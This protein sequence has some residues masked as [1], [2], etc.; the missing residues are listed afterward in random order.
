MASR[1]HTEFFICMRNKASMNR[2]YLAEQVT[3]ER[4]TLVEHEMTDVE[5]NAGSRLLGG[6][7]PPEWLDALDDVQ[8]HLDR[9]PKKITE[10]ETLHDKHL[11]RPT[12]DD[13]AEDERRIET[14]TKEISRIF[15]HAQGLLL[16]IKAK[17][18]GKAEEEILRQNVMRSV[19][20]ALQDYSASFRQVQSSYVRALKSREDWSDPYF[21]V[22]SKM[23]AEDDL[24]ATYSNGLEDALRDPLFGIK[25]PDSVGGI[26]SQRQLL[27]RMEEDTSWADQRDKEISQIVKSIVQ[28]NELFR[29]LSQMVVEQGTVLD[30]IDYNIENSSVSV[31]EGLQQLRKAET[32]QRKNRKI[33]CIMALAGTSVFLL[34]ILVLDGRN[35]VLSNSRGDRTTPTVVAVSSEERLIGA[36]AKQ[37][38]GRPGIDI[39]QG[40]KA[41]V[42]NPDPAQ[43][44]SLWPHSGFV[45]TVESGPVFALTK[46]GDSQEVMSVEEALNIVFNEFMEIARS[47]VTKLDENL[48]AVLTVP[49]EFD[50]QKT[51]I[52]KRAAANA[53]FNVIQA[54][55][56]PA[57]AVL[58]YDIAQKDSLCTPTCLV[59]RVGGTTSDITIVS[60]TSG[61]YSIEGHRYYATLGGDLLTKA[62]ADHFRSEF[63]SKYKMDPCE[64]SRRA[65]HKLFAAAEEC[66]HVLST[67]PSSSAFVESLRDGVDFSSNVTRARFESVANVHWDRFLVPVREILA[68]AGLG[69][70]DIDVVILAG[71]TMKIPKLQKLVK[72]MF[73]E[74]TTLCFSIP[75]DEVVAVGAAQQAGIKANSAL[76]APPA[77]TELVCLSRGIFFQIGEE[78][79]P[80]CL[81]AAKTLIPAH[82]VE[83]LNDNIEEGRISLKFFEADCLKE[84]HAETA[85]FL[86]S[87]TLDSLA[88]DAHVNVS[89]S[90]SKI[91]SGVNHYLILTSRSSRGSDLRICEWALEKMPGALSLSALASCVSFWVTIRLVRK[92]KNTFIA[93]GISGKDLCKKDH[94][95]IP[96]A[97][98]V[99]SGCIFLVVMSALL[100]ATFGHHLISG[101]KN[102]FP[103][104]EFV[105][106]L[107]G[108]LSI[109][110]MILL[111]F[112]DDVLNLR[113]R[114]K[115]L[116]PMLAA[117]PLLCVYLVNFNS[118]TII[119]PRPLRVLCGSSIDLG[120]FYYVYMLLI[121][122][123]CTNAINIYAG[124]NGLETGQTLVI[125]LSIALFNVGE[126]ILGIDPAAHALSLYFILPFLG[127]TGA[128]FYLNFY[129]AEVFVGD[130]FCY[131]A[132]MTIAVVGILGHFSKTV[133][134]FLLP[135]LANFLYGLPQLFRLIPCPRHR[136][137]RFNPE[138]DVVGVSSVVFNDK[139]IG[140][141][142]SACLKIYRML[143]II[144]YEEG[145]VDYSPKEVGEGDKVEDRG[146]GNGLVRC[147][148][149]T[150]INLYLKIFG[151][152][153]EHNLVTGLLIF[154]GLSSLVAFVIRYPLAGLF[155]DT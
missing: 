16:E 104:H 112:A 106:H 8:C 149:L 55:A 89:C 91:S 60:T 84:C 126:L 88:E 72:D 58:A 79:K 45:A 96:E 103:Y 27:L 87:L 4:D 130:T 81:L 39:V 20:M 101:N 9:L 132:G 14:L 134:L 109:C 85:T 69:F 33:L 56:E 30:R 77:L 18:R 42:A 118:T 131:F 11:N 99:L 111:G 86:G 70:D 155:Y 49:V 145:V 92:F 71:G 28:L 142:G 151:S 80:R 150:L 50:D 114:H 37:R 138:K 148:N 129:P 143:G 115:I 23:A 108:M 44:L 107:A 100:P 10:L 22:P 34:I 83:H 41:L 146:D 90:V 66:K 6:Q 68:D 3:N 123:F 21:A 62:L 53:G 121:T 38:I 133:M 75:A 54:I 154:Q 17:P 122:V 147:N 52:L 13:S 63:S 7:K 36:T 46:A 135:Q 117:L 105:E 97:C 110:C 73:P 152:T 125:A 43:S 93:A 153:S 65:Y 124:V 67:L 95:V 47:Q 78:G 116:L 61:L 128:L 57:A 120:M 24:N 127:T 48:K 15:S 2:H 102:V 94:P 139:R 141:I 26:G 119:I 5:L 40:M 51:D 74:N 31:H 82:H 29:D 25:S 76:S 64:D 19:A 1:S 32:Y 136:L 12:F 140:R 98:G 113:W 144:H 137:P 59:Y 35:A